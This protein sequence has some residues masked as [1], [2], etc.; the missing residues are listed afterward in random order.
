MLRTIDRPNDDMPND[1]S[2]ISEHSPPA[3]PTPP[4]APPLGP[5]DVGQPADSEALASPRFSSPKPAARATGGTGLPACRHVR[6]ASWPI[7]S[8]P[9]IRVH[10]PPSPLFPQPLRRSRFR[11]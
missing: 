1:P 11:T 5:A 4:K 9:L 3:A 8:R 7:A 2:P 6:Q 10:L